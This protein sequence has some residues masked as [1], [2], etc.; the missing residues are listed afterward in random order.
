MV[1]ARIKFFVSRCGAGVAWGGQNFKLFFLRFSFLL[2]RFHVMVEREF[3][4]ALVGPHAREGQRE[5]GRAEGLARSDEAS[6]EFEGEEYLTREP[7]DSFR[8]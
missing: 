2:A 3:G 4:F 5:K 8:W 6:S 7:R 1:S